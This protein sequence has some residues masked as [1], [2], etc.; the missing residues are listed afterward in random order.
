[1]SLLPSW[2]CWLFGVGEDPTIPLNMSGSYR[3]P[4]TNVRPSRS[5]QARQPLPAA[6]PMC[7]VLSCLVPRTNQG[8]DAQQHVSKFQSDCW[9]CRYRNVFVSSEIG[10]LNICAKGTAKWLSGR[11]FTIQQHVMGPDSMCS[12]PDVPVSQP[13]AL[14]NGHRRCRAN[15]CSRAVRLVCIWPAAAPSCSRANSRPTT[16]SDPPPTLNM[17]G[18]R[19]HLRLWA[20]LVALA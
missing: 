10:N 6:C 1:M 9:W 17:L 20:S 14:F 4:C 8:C 2:V 3:A 13:T 16:T 5:V 11:F 18:C 19:V 15:A 12:S 7:G